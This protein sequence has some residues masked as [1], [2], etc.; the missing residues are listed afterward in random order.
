MLAVN[1]HVNEQLCTISTGGTAEEFYI[2][3]KRSQLLFGGS[4]KYDYIDTTIYIEGLS[5]NARF[6][7]P[8][9]IVRYAGT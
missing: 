8:L 5:S 9:R 3:G 2:F 7:A 1:V 4:D 6:Q